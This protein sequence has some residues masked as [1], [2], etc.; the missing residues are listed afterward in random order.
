MKWAIEVS[1]KA[2]R[3]LRKLD[4][5]ARLQVLDDLLSLQNDPCPPSPK[6]R[7]LR[8]FRIATYRFRSG[9]YRAI[10]R[11]DGGKVVIGAV[12]HRKDLE[13][14]VGVF[15]RCAMGQ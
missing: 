9:D 5:P 4:P 10:Y 3:Q 6:S 12:F 8:G 14:E 13:R 1:P 15:V 11:V 7:K 2:H